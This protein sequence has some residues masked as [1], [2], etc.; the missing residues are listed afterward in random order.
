M[1]GLLTRK[2]A[3]DRSARTAKRAELVVG[4]PRVLNMWNTH[5]FWIGF[6]V[7]LGIKPEH[8]VFSSETSEEQFKQFGKGRGTVDCCFPVKCISGHYG[9]LLTHKKKPRVLLS[10]MIY[11]LP[12]HLRGHVLDTLSCPRV[13][14]APEN[15]KAGFL[16]E[17][18]VFQE[19]GMVYVSPFVSLAEPHLVPKQLCESLQ[20][21]LDLDL[22]E[23]KEAVEAGFR[24]LRDFTERMRAK[25][26]EILG[27]CARE[28][29]PCVLVLAR[30]YHMD[31]GIGHEIEVDLQ[32]NGYPILWTQYLPVDA[33]LTEWLFGKEIEA[34][35][36]K[37]PFDI[38]DVWMSAY[39]SNTNEI[40]W[41]AKVAA[42]MPWIVCAIH[43]SSYECGMDQ[44]TYTPVQQIVE[45]SG[46]L[47]FKFGDL[48][49]TKP[50]GSIRI[51][52]ET[53]H[54]YIQQSYPGIIEK[55]LRRLPVPC[56]LLTVETVQSPTEP[57]VPARP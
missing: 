43:L 12:S 16:K 9:E 38:S 37:S 5:Q 11:S 46:T 51:R 29:K 28:Q 33:D 52:V 42:R 6:L 24:A 8:I 18:D 45:R 27:W 15:I 54:Y 14:A 53:V 31:S 35:V 7:A 3:P 39:S 22:E 47:Y 32:A 23:T 10:P 49:S 44:P 1:L 2:K 50:G 13:M 36:V 30:P 55:K 57:A 48:D 40:I 4:I 26:R 17:R 56:P 20:E 41:A 25:A 34:G 21:V 19:H